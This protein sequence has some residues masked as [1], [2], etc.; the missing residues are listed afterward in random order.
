MSKELA[1]RQATSR[2]ESGLQ[3]LKVLPAVQPWEDA[4]ANHTSVP[5]EKQYMARDSE[6]PIMKQNIGMFKLRNGA[7]VRFGTY[8]KILMHSFMRSSPS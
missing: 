6:Q 5:A 2:Y 8:D 4:T 7:E 1:D 3:V